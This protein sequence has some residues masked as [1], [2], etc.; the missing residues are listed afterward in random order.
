MHLAYRFNL[1]KKVYNVQIK[2]RVRCFPV[3]RNNILF[4]RN[5]V[6]TD[7]LEKMTSCPYSFNECEDSDLL[8]VQNN[9]ELAATYSL[10]II[11]CLAYIIFQDFWDS[12]NNDKNL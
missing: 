8:L 7:T 10:Y 9:K 12:R 3:D 1:C 4:T 2:N 6:L 5:N 11:A